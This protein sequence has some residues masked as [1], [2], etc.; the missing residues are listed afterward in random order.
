[1]RTM[2]THTS[3]ISSVCNRL[4]TRTLMHVQRGM[5]C[6]PV[7]ARIHTPRGAYIRVLNVHICASPCMCTYYSGTVKSAGQQRVSAGLRHDILGGPFRLNL[8]VA[9]LRRRSASF[10]RTICKSFGL[11]VR[12]QGVTFETRVLF[13][14]M[15]FDATIIFPPL[16]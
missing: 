8:G 9:P 12:G 16:L 15:D 11:E 14:A 6:A 2:Y 4:C 3:E 5:A 13:P 10:D 7:L 1:M